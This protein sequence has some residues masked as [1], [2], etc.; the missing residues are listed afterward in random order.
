MNHPYLGMRPGVTVIYYLLQKGEKSLFHRIRSEE[1][2]QFVMGDPLELLTLSPN[3][4]TIQTQALSFLSSG[5]SFFSV[6]P[7]VWQAARTTGEYSLVLCTVSP[8]FFFSDLEF[9]GSSHLQNAS[10][11]EEQNILVSPYLLKM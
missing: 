3:F 10:L 5:S 1:V 11:S 8:G 7:G 6:P 4:S 9:L 2:W